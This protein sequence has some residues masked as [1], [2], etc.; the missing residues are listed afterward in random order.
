[1]I[2]TN[3]QSFLSLHEQ[4]AQEFPLDLRD[5]DL[6]QGL[7]EVHGRPFQRVPGHKDQKLDHQSQ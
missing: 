1:V 3:L 2:A 6:P 7:K 5:L 4:L